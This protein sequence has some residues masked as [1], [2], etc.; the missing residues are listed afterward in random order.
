[1]QI[2]FRPQAEADIADIWAYTDEIWGQQKAADYLA[3]LE[4]MLQSVAA[5]PEM[6]RLRSDFDPPVRIH[7]FRKHLIIYQTDGTMLDVIR[8]LHSRSNWAQF[9]TE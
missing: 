7:P 3:A 1:M 2:L 4:Q 6:A 8:I 5:F 9:L